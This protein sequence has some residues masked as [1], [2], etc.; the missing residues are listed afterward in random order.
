MRGYSPEES[1][2]SRNYKYKAHYNYKS[3][4]QRRRETYQLQFVRCKFLNKVDNAVNL[5]GKTF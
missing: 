2:N 1:Y 5:K 3:N 4:F